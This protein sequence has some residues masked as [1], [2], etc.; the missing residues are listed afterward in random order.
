VKKSTRV[1]K[2]DWLARALGVL[3]EVGIEG[4]RIERLAR[5]LGVAKS[6]FYYHFSDRP[7]L[8]KQMLKY[9]SDEFTESMLHSPKVHEGTPDDRLFSMMEM[10]EE[11]E[12]A[13][14]DLAVRSWAEHDPLAKKAVRRVYRRR[15]AFVSELFKQ[16]GFRGQE[17]EMRA[18]LFVC[19]HSW[20]QTVVANT[21][22]AKRRAMRQLR[23][24][25]LIKK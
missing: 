6:G 1:S 2:A 17:L 23:R 12:L 11:Q 15:L 5:D 24:A 18:Q 19:Y 10:I 21:T 16:L 25:F 14:F 7:D 8:L 22:K 4:V 20:Q 3:E 13:K 9:W